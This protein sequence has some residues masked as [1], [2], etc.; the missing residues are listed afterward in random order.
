MSIVYSEVCGK[1]GRKI[2]KIYFS[3]SVSRVS[4]ALSLLYYISLYIS[5]EF[6]TGDC[7]FMHNKYNFMYFSSFLST[8]F[9]S[10]SLSSTSHL[11]S[12]YSKGKEGGTVTAQHSTCVCVWVETGREGR[13]G[14]LFSLLNY[15][16]Q[17]GGNREGREE[18]DTSPPPLSIYKAGGQ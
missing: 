5:P 14:K 9:L 18:M 12:S 8:S 2:L 6:R 16:A 4:R 17:M 10:C 7:I 3:L 1:T 13:K 15:T 11:S